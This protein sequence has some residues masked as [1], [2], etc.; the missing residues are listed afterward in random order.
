MKGTTVI[1]PK[2]VTDPKK[3]GLIVRNALVPITPITPF[4]AVTRFSLSEYTLL[5]IDIAFVNSFGSSFANSSIARPVATSVT[6]SFSFI[7]SFVLEPNP[8]NFGK[9][10]K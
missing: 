7:A 10:E 3:A 4:T 9:D 8:V 5:K 1:I 2:T 6:I